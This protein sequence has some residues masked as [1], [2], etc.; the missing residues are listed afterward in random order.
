MAGGW[1]IVVRNWEYERRIQ[2]QKEREYEQARHEESLR[3]LKTDHRSYVH[4][5]PGEEEKCYALEEK[6]IKQLQKTEQQALCF[7]LVQKLVLAHNAQVKRLTFKENEYFGRSGYRAIR[8]SFSRYYYYDPVPFY[9]IIQ[10]MQPPYKYQINV[11]TH[12][13]VS[14]HG[15]LYKT[16][17]KQI[18][19]GDRY[20]DILEASYVYGLWTITKSGLDAITMNMQNFMHT[21]Y[22]PNLQNT[23]VWSAERM[24]V[25]KFLDRLIGSYELQNRFIRS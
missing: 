24:A 12:E 11:Y 25:F 1:D 5:L 15:T 21:D 20:D 10:Y 3:R 18:I 14:E 4:M 6:R 13:I 9:D 2:E 8:A 22:K 16:N 17:Q 7:T 19:F 23:D